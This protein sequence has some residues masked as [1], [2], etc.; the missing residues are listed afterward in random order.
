MSNVIQGGIF[1]SQAWKLKA[2]YYDIVLTHN[3]QA[4]LPTG[5]VTNKYLYAALI[6]DDASRG[7]QTIVGFAWALDGTNQPLLTV[8]LQSASGT[9]TCRVCLL[10]KI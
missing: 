2:E 6:C 7:L 5:P 3:V 4:T 8:Q 9:L 10:Y 1:D